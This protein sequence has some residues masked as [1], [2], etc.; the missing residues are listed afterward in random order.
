MDYS[1]ELRRAS[2]SEQRVWVPAR[3]L[4]E[5]VRGAVWGHA[6]HAWQELAG[7]CLLIVPMIGMNVGEPNF[8]SEC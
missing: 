2:C 1:V 6:W 7:P 5:L 3:V 8:L 4:S